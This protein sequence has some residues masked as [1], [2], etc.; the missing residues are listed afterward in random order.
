MRGF[1]SFYRNGLL[2]PEEVFKQHWRTPTPADV[3][4]SQARRWVRAHREVS[5]F[6]LWLHYFDP[7]DPYLPPYSED[8][9]ALSWGS[10]SQMTGHIRDTDL[11]PRRGSVP[12]PVNE[13]DRR[14]LVDLYDA[15]IRYLDQALGELFVVLE[16]DQLFDDSLIIVTA[17]HGESLGEH[18]QWTHGT[19]LF[20]QQIHV[21]LIVKYPGQRSAQ[22][23]SSPVE[24]LDIVPTILEVAGVETSAPLNGRSLVVPATRG[25]AFVFWK[26]EWVV[27]TGE[28]K[29]LHRAGETRLYHIS[30]DPGETTDLSGEHP[31]VVQSLIRARTARLAQID[32]SEGALEDTAA[33]ALEE[34]RALGYLE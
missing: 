25:A 14:H 26:D 6:F 17:D 21:P 30:D 2:C 8:M 33:D 20:D 32:A 11:F 28:W 13:V 27:R 16:E 10:G 31:E 24:A 18:G 1:E 9:E 23:V 4:T 22:R 7:H 19:S 3:V 12:P 5:P 34:M 29:L 15:E